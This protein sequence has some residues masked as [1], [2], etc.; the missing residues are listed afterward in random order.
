MPFQVF[1]L[2]RNPYQD[3][4]V[5]KMNP[6]PAEPILHTE[7]APLRFMEQQAL[8]CSIGV[9]WKFCGTREI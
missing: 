2:L 6:T 4:T 1:F 8:S 5:L 7:M 3:P 9:P